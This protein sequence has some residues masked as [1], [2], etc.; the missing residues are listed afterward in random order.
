M[1]FIGRKRVIKL[2]RIG[3]PS[4]VI[5]E[6]GFTDDDKFVYVS[7]KDNDIYVD[8]TN[9]K[10]EGIPVRCEPHTGRIVIPNS[11]HKTLGI[12][13]DNELDI[14]VDA[15]KGY[16]ILRKTNYSREIEVVKQL[17]ATSKRLDADERRE[18]DILLDIL[19]DEERDRTHENKN[20][21]H[22]GGKWRV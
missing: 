16:V 9:G 17:A 10:H 14:Y 1:K 19:M 20:K 11:I 5:R 6:I 3:L 13:E 7:L 18:L 2:K 12:E 15:D 22:R 21:Q 8:V 4:S